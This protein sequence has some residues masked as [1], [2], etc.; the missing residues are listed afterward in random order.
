MTTQIVQLQLTLPRPLFDKL[1][2]AARANDVSV[3]DVIAESLDHVFPAVPDLP[4]AVLRDLLAMTEYADEAL[5]DIVRAPG[6]AG[7]ERLRQLTA[8][9]K[10]RALSE[11]EASEQT[12]LLEASQLAVLRRAQAIAVLRRRGYVVPGKDLDGEDV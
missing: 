4:P 5:L 3:A 9:S 11:D 6:H 2:R 1:Q 10:T 12:R 7:D 8:L